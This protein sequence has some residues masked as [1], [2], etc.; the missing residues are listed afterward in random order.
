MAR[1][2]TQ[3]Q[4][5]EGW[6]IMRKRAREISLKGE[7]QRRIGRPIYIEQAAR[8]PNQARLSV[9]ARSSQADS[10]QEVMELDN[11]IPNEL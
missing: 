4:P 2:L 3:E 1:T 6:T 9:N 8:D 7:T 5:T 11:A 10:S